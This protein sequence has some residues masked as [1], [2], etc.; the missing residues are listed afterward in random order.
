MM[1]SVSNEEGGGK[2]MQGFGRTTLWK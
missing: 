1:K 2:C